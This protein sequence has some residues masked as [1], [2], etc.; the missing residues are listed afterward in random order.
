MFLFLF[1]VPVFLYAVTVLIFHIKRIISSKK[2]LKMPKI[3]VGRTTLKGERK[4][5]GLKLI[6]V[7]YFNR[8]ASVHTG[9]PAKRLQ[10]FHTEQVSL[11]RSG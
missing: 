4:E 5:D 2:S 3:W 1:L 9:F 11:P 7:F 8:L 6:F 10:K